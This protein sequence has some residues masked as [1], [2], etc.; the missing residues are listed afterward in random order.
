MSHNSNKTMRS[1]SSNRNDAILGNEQANTAADMVTMTS[2]TMR[3]APPPRPPIS[4][5][6]VRK[7][8]RKSFGAPPAIG[9]QSDTAKKD[10]RKLSGNPGSPC[11]VV[12]AD[13][14][15]K[16]ES[17]DPPVKSFAEH[18]SLLVFPQK[19]DSAPE[20]RYEAILRETTERF[21]PDDQRVGIVMHNLGMVYLNNHDFVKAEQLFAKAL[22]VFEK[23]STGSRTDVAVS[24]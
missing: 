9:I 19:L 7:S 14:G 11:S 20:S 15:G 24:V 5:A 2:K 12:G 23:S 22:Y 10:S 13:F 17:R 18:P 8:N 4:P 21:G 3:L 6:S 1:R 16:N